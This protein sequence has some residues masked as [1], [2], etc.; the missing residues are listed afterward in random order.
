MRIR[1]TTLRHGRL[2]RFKMVAAVG[3]CT[4]SAT[5]GTGLF[6][7]K[8]DHGRLADVLRGY[9]HA[10]VVLSYYDAPRIRQLY[11]GW[12]VVEKT[13]NKQ[14]HAQNGR[15]ARQ[16]DAPEILLINGL[17]YAA[18]GGVKGAA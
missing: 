8:D 15:G 6:G 4:S 7:A 18:A 2:D 16:K 3:I 14:L 5:A 13:M 17:S 11:Q 9:R 10:R 12:T 1:L